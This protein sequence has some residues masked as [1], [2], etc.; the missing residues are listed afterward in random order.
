MNEAANYGGLLEFDLDGFG[1]PALAAL[2]CAQVVVWLLRWLNTGK[3]GEEAAFRAWR[4]I[5]LDWV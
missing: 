1:V 3:L 2:K 4:T 5:Y